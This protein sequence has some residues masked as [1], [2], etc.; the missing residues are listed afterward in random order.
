MP[1]VLWLVNYVLY[2]INALEFLRLADLTA[3]IRDTLLS[4]SQTCGGYFVACFVPFVVRPRQPSGVAWNA[5]QSLIPTF[6][7]AQDFMKPKCRSGT[8]IF[9]QPSWRVPN[10][11]SN[12]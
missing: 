2:S 7:S 1:G 6:R 9:S 11:T 12:Y 4:R 3:L 10:I 8:K 5:G